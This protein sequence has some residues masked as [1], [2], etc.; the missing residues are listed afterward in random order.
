MEK[1]DKASQLSAVCVCA[2]VVV[3]AA[4]MCSS[5]FHMMCCV[6]GMKAGDVM[7]G[8]TSYNG[9]ICEIPLSGVLPTDAFPPYSYGTISMLMTGIS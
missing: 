8:R 2:H 9:G 1:K 7:G 6:N 3:T 4:P 5:V